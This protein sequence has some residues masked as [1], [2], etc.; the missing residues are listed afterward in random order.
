MYAIAGTAETNRSPFD[1]ARRRVGT[2]GR[3]LHRYSGFKFALFFLGEYRGDVFDLRAWVRRCFSVDGR[4][5]W[6]LCSGFRRGSGSSGSC[7]S[8]C[9]CSSGARNAAAAAPGSADELRLEV[10]AADVPAESV[11]R[12]R[13]GDFM[14]EGWLRWMVC[15]AILIVAYVVHGPRGDAKQDIRTEEL[16]LCRVVSQRPTDSMN[17]RLRPK[18][19]GGCGIRLLIYRCAYGRRRAGGG[20]AEEP[21]ALRAGADGGVRRA[22]AAV[23]CSSTRSLPASRRSWSTSARSR[24][25]WCSR[26]CSRAGRRRPKMAVSSARHGSTGLAIAAA[27]FAVLG[28]GSPA[29]QG[30]VCRTRPLHPP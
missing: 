15:S 22:G 18:V 30:L 20:A 8:R 27:V 25:W 9:A 29:E 13:C 23:S 10:R 6:Q 2:G 21:G 3:L 5:R 7:C 14:G 26:F 17:E 1:L 16:S 24:S 4:L 19:S 11:R 12:R 28:L